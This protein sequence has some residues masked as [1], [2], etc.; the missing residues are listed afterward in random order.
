MIGYPK[1]Q[2]DKQRL[3]LYK[4]EFILIIFLKNVVKYVVP[5]PS[6]IT[7]IH[8]TLIQTEFN[9]NKSW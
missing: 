1:N 3:L 8:K 7:L 6:T 5:S 2:T 4:V 9:S